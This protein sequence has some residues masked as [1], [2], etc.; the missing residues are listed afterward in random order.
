MCFVLFSW[1]VV[2]WI[3]ICD[4]RGKKKIALVVWD[5]HHSVNNIL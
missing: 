4:E 3:A 5:L 1:R 2:Q